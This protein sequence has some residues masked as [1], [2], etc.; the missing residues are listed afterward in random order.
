LKKSLSI[1]LP[2]KSQSGDV[3]AVAFLSRSDT[4]QV[5][6]ADQSLF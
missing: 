3:R 2:A 1:S 6:G 5:I 4:M